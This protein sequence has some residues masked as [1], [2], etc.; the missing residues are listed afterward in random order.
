MEW[1]ELVASLFVILGG[2]ELFT[3]GVEWIGEGFG[4][5]EGA[6]GSVLAA[7]GT[8]LPETLLPLIAILSGHA[9]GEEI[10]IGAILGAPLMLTTLAMFV[11]AVAVFGYS[12][13]NGR[14]LELK[15]NAAVLRQDLGYFLAMYAL[16]MVAGLV[17]VRPLHWGL[18]VILVVGYVFYVRRHFR[19]SP[20]PETQT[21]AQGEVKPLYVWSWLRRLR[22]SLPSWSKRSS[23]WPSFVQ[24]ALALGLIIGGA[25]LFVFA[26]DVIGGRFHVSHLVFALLVA[27]LATELPEKFNSVLWVRRGKD[28][29]ALGNMTGAMVFQSSFPVTVG[30]LL[31]PWDLAHEALVAA[32]I[33][34]AAGSLLYAT[35]RMRRR[36]TAPLLLIQGAFYV[37]YVTYVLTR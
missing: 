3:N 2:A 4:L 32:A 20:D 11:I 21:E 14:S 22:P 1:P 18:S 25:R 16:A 12:R 24:V 5:S 9:S 6:V 36:F 27:P 7:V 29:L 26:V 31:T 13:A 34:L 30:L 19:A 23:E 15:G 35:I 17:H 10:G 37:A 28:T 8:A 33:A